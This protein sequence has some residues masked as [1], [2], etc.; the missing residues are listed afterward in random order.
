MQ[1]DGAWPGNT[2]LIWS[3]VSVKRR[4]QPVAHRADGA[5]LGVALAFVQ[6]G[7]RG[8]GR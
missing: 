3:P 5:V 6:K 1:V 4:L 7:A 8:V 2:P